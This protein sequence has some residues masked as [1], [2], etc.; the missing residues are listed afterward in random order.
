MAEGYLAQQLRDVGLLDDLQV[1]VGGVATEAAHGGGGVVDGDAALAEQGFDVGLP[2]GLVCGVH[3]PP[4]VAEEHLAEDLPH[5][6]RAVGIKKVH[7]PPLARRRE[8]AEHQ[9]PCVGRQEGPQG[10]ALDG[11]WVGEDFL[12]GEG[13]FISLSANCFNAVSDSL[14]TVHSSM[15]TAP[16]ER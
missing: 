14:W 10:V 3:Q 2:E 4:A 6:V 9:Q 8:A 16:M 12:H 11:Y 5:H 13:Q 15:G 1:F 7:A